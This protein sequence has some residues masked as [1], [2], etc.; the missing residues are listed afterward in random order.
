MLF[1]GA[2]YSV[3]HQYMDPTVR[4]LFR[5][6]QGKERFICLQSLARHLISTMHFFV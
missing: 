1:G 6:Y 5:K 4:K 3:K 2:Q